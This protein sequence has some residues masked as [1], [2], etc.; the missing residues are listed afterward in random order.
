MKLK[1][2]MD[3]DVLSFFGKYAKK[4]GEIEYNE[5]GVD[6]VKIAKICNIKIKCSYTSEPVDFAKNYMDIHEK[7]TRGSEEDKRCIYIYPIAPEY[8]NYEKIA[9][10]ITQIIVEDMNIDYIGMEF[11]YTENLFD[12]LMLPSRIYY[13]CVLLALKASL[14]DDYE[15]F[16]IEEIWELNDEIARI[17]DVDPSYTLNRT[18]SKLFDFS[19]GD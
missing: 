12:E 19:K 15:P 18:F 7:I 17:A 1:D 6:V 2:V 3:K 14:K 11:E 4:V 9:L 10:G 13:A 16:S 5:A 8:E